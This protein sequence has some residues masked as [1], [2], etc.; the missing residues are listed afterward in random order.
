MVTG[1]IDMKTSNLR[2]SFFG[3]NYDVL[4]SLS[5]APGVD[6]ISVFTKPEEG[7]DENIK[8]VKDYSLSL[9][10]PVFQPTKKELYSYAGILKE[11]DLD[12]II[13]C[14]YKFIIP[15]EIFSIPKRGTINIHP[16][17]LPRY[18]GQHVINWAIIN[19][20]KETGVTLHFMDDTLDTGDIILQK[21]VPIQIED[22]AKELHNRIYMEA[23]VLLRQLLVDVR[24]GKLLIGKKQISEDATFFKPRKP[25]DGLI[26]WNKSSV[27]IYNLIRALSKP[28]PGAF[29]YMGGNKVIIWKVQIHDSKAVGSCGKIIKSSDDYLAVYTA[30]GHIRIVDYEFVSEDC[31]KDNMKLKN[32]DF[33]E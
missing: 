22:T 23:C 11:I 24:H 16:S 20:E 33:F 14:G 17:M 4:E 19:G 10:V 1:L 25:Q 12:L 2:I 15:R 6:L 27:E 3:N 7:S 18:R 21:K 5:T 13:V 30:D 28:W 32:G 29:T 31:N 8:K 26:D 9:G